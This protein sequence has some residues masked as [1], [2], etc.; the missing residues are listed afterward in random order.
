MVWRVDFAPGAER[1]FAIILDHLTNAYVGLGEAPP[2]AVARAIER[3][4]AIRSNADRLGLAPGV[5]ALREDIGEGLRHVTFDRAIHWF[6]ADGGV[7]TV[8]A[9]FLAGEDHHHKART[10][11]RRGFGRG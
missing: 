8:L 3:V 7:V 6:I 1:D 10:R 11:R 2:S 5:G 4:R 9:V